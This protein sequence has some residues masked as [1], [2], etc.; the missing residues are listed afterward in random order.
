MK[1]DIIFIKITNINSILPHHSTTCNDATMSAALRSIGRGC[2]P[3][4]GEL[5]V[6]TPQPLGAD[7]HRHVGAPD[8]S[9]GGAA[10]TTE[11]PVMKGIRRC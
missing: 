2:P 10:A 7:A 5:E 11:G 6:L 8:R 3:Q 4:T 1:R 9:D